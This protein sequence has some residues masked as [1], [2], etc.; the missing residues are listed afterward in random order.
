M[1]K[2]IKTP[3]YQA[4]ARGW[5]KITWAKTGGQPKQPINKI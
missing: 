2:I 5:N 1:H 4:Y 3:I